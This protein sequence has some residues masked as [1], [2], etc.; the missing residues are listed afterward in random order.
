LNVA[1][2][3]EVSPIPPGRYWIN[4]LGVDAMRE[5]QEWVR[6]MAGGVQIE[7][8]SLDEDATPPVEFVIFQVPE[9]R[10]PFL[11]AH[12]F[13]FPNHAPANVRSSS[14]VE[15]SPKADIKSPVEEVE[16]F[17]SGLFS[18]AKAL[19]LLVLLFFGLK[20]K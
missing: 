10:S 20:G 2:Q 14:D 17:G 7:T 12:V 4:V 6:D 3:R 1:L 18:D 11:N 9:G 16:A 19:V 5:F 13:G 8:V 15:Q